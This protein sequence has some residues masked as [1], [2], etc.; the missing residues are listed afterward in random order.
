MKVKI[1]LTLMTLMIVWGCTNQSNG[2]QVK[3]E[4]LSL[5]DYFPNMEDIALDW[6][7]DAA[8]TKISIDVI[9]PFTARKTP[10]IDAVFESKEVEGEAI[11]ITCTSSGCKSY[12]YDISYSSFDY[13]DPIQ[14]DKVGLD[15][16]DVVEIAIDQGAM[17][18]LRTE[19][20]YGDLRLVYIEET[21][22]WFCRF[23]S[24]GSSLDLYIEPKSGEILEI[25]EKK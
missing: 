25:D 16:G 22:V 3:Y 2:S 24:T 6:D 15:S 14:I 1:V 13:I 18:H 8:L 7:Q 10:R 5:N 19:G 20:G 4:V 9:T 17:A 23:S 21:L 12:V 11:A